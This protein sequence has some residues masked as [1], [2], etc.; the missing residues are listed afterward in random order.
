MEMTNIIAMG[1]YHSLSGYG[2]RFRYLV[3]DL[4]NLYDNV[5]VVP[6][7]WGRTV[8]NMSLKPD[9]AIIR[10]DLPEDIDI[11]IQCTVPSE[12]KP[13]GTTNIGITAGIETDTI[14]SNWIGPINA[15]DAVFVSSSFSKSSMSK[16]NV[17]TPIRVLNERVS[18]LAPNEDELN[19]DNKFYFFASGAWVTGDFGYDR[20]N[21]PYLVSCF[22]KAFANEEVQPG[23]MLKTDQGTYSR[24]ERDRMVE[25][26]NNLIDNFKTLYPDS[27]VPDIKFIHG[28]LTDQEYS[29]LIHHP[30]IKAF[31]SI[32][33]G[34]GFGRIPAEFLSTNKPIL[35]SKLG[36]HADFVKDSGN[37][38]VDGVMDTV[39]QSNINQYIVPESKWFYPNEEDVIYGFVELYT[40]Y[41]EYIVKNN[42][43]KRY[44][45]LSGQQLV[46]KLDT[47]IQQAIKSK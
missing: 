21:I 44:D 47:Y 11:F 33:H 42:N 34:E 25:L 31:A 12:F 28:H 37:Y 32:T 10:Y 36:G 19:I 4:E 22:L 6:I 38:L 35:I 40:K 39:H 30:N 8:N 24:I 29:N 13:L 26:F 14:P 27:K 41:D 20:K 1:P 18:V 7:N 2:V 17:Q 46:K 3:E 45:K 23:L 5:T 9:K 16:A 43:K 15:M